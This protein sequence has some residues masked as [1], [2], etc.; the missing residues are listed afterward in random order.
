M[1]T[2]W[3]KLDTLVVELKQVKDEMTEQS[4]DPFASR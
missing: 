2:L 3:R 4:M 1:E